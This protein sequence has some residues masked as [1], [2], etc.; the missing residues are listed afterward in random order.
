MK[1]YIEEEDEMLA[2][3]KKLS[4]EEILSDVDLTTRRSKI[5]ATLGYSFLCILFL[6]LIN[7]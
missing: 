5:I 7:S 6:L 2:T 4:I 3:F 1:H